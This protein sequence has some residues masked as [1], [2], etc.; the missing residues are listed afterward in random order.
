M[1]TTKSKTSFTVQGDF[2]EYLRIV[3]II[4]RV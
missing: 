3:F 4:V 2:W 1:A